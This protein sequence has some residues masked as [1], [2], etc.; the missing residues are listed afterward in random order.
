MLRLPNLIDE[1][2][3]Q[4]HRRYL[5]T[6][7]NQSEYAQNLCYTK[8]SSSVILD[9]DVKMLRLTNLIDEV[10]QRAHRRYLNTGNKQSHHSIA[11]E[12]D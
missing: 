11:L 9:L 10:D 6:E 1:V 3:L 4:A 2:D 7:A 5:N 12:T 8:L